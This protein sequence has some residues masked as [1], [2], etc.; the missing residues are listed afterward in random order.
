MQP[1]LMFLLPGP[2]YILE[3]TVVSGRI[4]CMQ[5]GF[6]YGTVSQNIAGHR[7]GNV[8]LLSR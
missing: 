7:Q 5:R 1:E 3:G 8:Y 4:E 6:S 2:D